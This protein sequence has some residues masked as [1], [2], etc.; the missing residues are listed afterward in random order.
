MENEIEFQVG[1][2][3]GRM[4]YEDQE[5]VNNLT[6]VLASN[7]TGYNFLGHIGRKANLQVIINANSLPSALLTDLTNAGYSVK[8]ELE[9]GERLKC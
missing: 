5:I 1:K 3:K 4:K 9:T 6:G 8:T 7:F 2:R